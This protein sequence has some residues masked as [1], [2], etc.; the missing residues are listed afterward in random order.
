[1]SLIR[2][3]LEDGAVDRLWGVL[4]R[5]PI[6]KRRAVASGAA[7]SSVALLA[8]AMAS[9]SGAPVLLVV[10]HVDDAETAGQELREDGCEVVVFPALETLP[11]ET[12][13]S[14]ELYGQRLGAMQ[15]LMAW[16]AGE[17]A[18]RVVV[19]PIQALM[20]PVPDPRRLGEGLLTL[21]AGETHAMD[22]VVR[23][24]DQ[25]GYT[26]VD[27]VSE[28]GEYAR[29]GGILDVFPPGDPGAQENASDVSARNG[30]NS[31]A[32]QSATEGELTLSMG[33][34]P[35]RLDFFGDQIDRVSEVDPDTMGSDRRVAGVRLVRASLDEPEPEPKSDGAKGGA[36]SRRATDDGVSVLDVMPSATIAVLGELMELTE[37][38]RGYLERVTE[39]RGIFGPPSV[40][41]KIIERCVGGVVES[42]GLGVSIGAPGRGSLGGASHAGA[43]GDDAVVE[44]PVSALASF[45]ED[46]RAGV[47]ELVELARGRSGPRVR[48]EVCCNSEGERARLLELLD[49]LDREQPDE[50]RRGEGDV[51]GAGRGAR[52]AGGDVGSRVQ[53][54]NAGFQ[55]GDRLLVSY[56]ELVHR[57]QTRR[58][59]RTGRL[60]AGRA[61]DTF[62]DL[63][64]GDYVVHSEHGIARFNGLSSV[65]ARDAKASVDQRLRGGAAGAGSAAG[66]GASA[67]A[68]RQASD[69]ELGEYLVLEFDAKAMLYVPASKADQVQKYIGG[70]KGKP[71]LSTLGGTRWKKQKEQ[72][73]ESV[74]DLAA[75]LLRVRA[76]REAVGGVSFPQDTDWQR[77]FEDAFAHEET[78]DQLAALAEI[79]RDMQS[80][81]P[82]DR[83]LCG[84]V[85]YGKTEMAVRAAFKA[86]EAGKQVAVL[87]PTT[88]LAE[89]HER[90]F[91]GRLAGY[92]FRVASLSRFKS[93]SEVRETL[94]GVARGEVDVVIGTHRLLSKDVVFKD[95]GLVVIDEEQRFGVEHKERLLS[96]RLTVDVLTLSATP[97]PRTLHM[98]MLGLRDISS[99]TTAPVERRAVV[100]EVIPYNTRRIEQALAR[101]LAR[102]GQAFFVHNKVSDIRSVADDVQRLAPGARVV[103]GHGQMGDGELEEVMLTFMRRQ[104]D[105]LVCTTIIESGID[106][107]S[108]NTIFINNADRFGLAE[109][110][111]LRGRVGR[112]K[113]RGYCYLLTDERKPLREVAKKRLK[114]IEQYSMLGAG[115]KIA[116]RDLEIRGAGNILGAE[117]SGH[118]AAVGY[119]MYCQ[120]L[121]RAVKQLRNE[122]TAAPSE[123]TLEIGVVG[124]IPKGYI[125]AD[126]RRLEA[127]RRVALASTAQEL[128]K[129]EADLV[130]AYGALPE[131]ARRLLDLSEVRIGARLVG[132]RSIVVRERDVVIRT[133][134]PGL[135]VERLSG[136]QG[137]VNSLPV[138]SPTEVPEVYFRPSNAAMLQA[139]T[140]LAVLRKRFGSERVA[141]TPGSDGRAMGVETGA[142]SGGAAR[143]RVVPGVRTSKPLMSGGVGGAKK[144]GALG[145]ADQS[146][147]K[148][149]RKLARETREHKPEVRDDGVT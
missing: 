142:A 21:R 89:Q 116:M 15:S 106:I 17:G 33:G 87:V 14:L 122:A 36:G 34:V 74:R 108:A 18:A 31:G 41:K 40:F 23:W 129:V 56:A 124:L 43:R 105:I 64:P 16:G 51:E 4:A 30:T 99:L 26:R 111:Q 59:A 130:A 107:A 5:A 84:D 10:A 119:D 134:E 9:R 39:S 47:R 19:A 81:R 45:D 58:R 82:M 139:T 70:F 24:L 25:A 61:L 123:T 117:Q 141:H 86:A 42:T 145:R 114:A 66:A 44:L 20:Q 75:E 35:V 133:S 91:R 52:A 76:A 69:D 55:W 118:I 112:G 67:G 63:Q 48:V 113:H 77:E 136:V 95:L 104:A 85:G 62:L 131:P 147:L 27:V 103:I 88:V 125:P 71:R 146:G 60:R 7:G 3:L 50:V 110:H 2:G 143:G 115:F 127:Y 32:R 38:G 65:K 120:L 144:P 92:P 94:A 126:I 1:M 138:R 101:E 100:S 22:Q 28:T 90:T 83:L 13:A 93:P 132:V 29:R 148:A 8:G 78:E 98:S 109:L 49:E 54:L 68:A 80:A 140:L 37:Q 97:I 53:F 79:K 73:S 102:E 46:P 57:F 121:D 137:S 128:A 72:V 12:S 135:V 149:L 96:L 11:G 6:G